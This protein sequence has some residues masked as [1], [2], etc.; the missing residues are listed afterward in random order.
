MKNV[1]KVVERIKDRYGKNEPVFKDEKGKV[2]YLDKYEDKDFVREMVP[3]VGGKIKC[4]VVKSLTHNDFIRTTI[5]G[6]GISTHIDNNNILNLSYFNLSRLGKEFVWFLNTI[7]NAELKGTTTFS[8][9]R[10]SPISTAFINSF[11][12]TWKSVVIDGLTF[13]NYINIMYY[14]HN[15]YS[16][17]TETTLPSITHTFSK[18][19]SNNSFLLNREQPLV[20]PGPQYSNNSYP[21]CSGMPPFHNFPMTGTLD[22][23]NKIIREIPLDVEHIVMYNNQVARLIVKIVYGDKDPIIIIAY[24][25]QFRRTDNPLVATVNKVVVISKDVGLSELQNLNFDQPFMP[26]D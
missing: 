8:I 7:Y 12:N 15:T 26:N 19:E 20:Q 18:I 2:A 16:E 17:I 21:D 13:T 25:Q 24:G 22:K 1:I 4:Y 23:F 14:I 11:P 10:D 5:N 3:A 6:T 9:I